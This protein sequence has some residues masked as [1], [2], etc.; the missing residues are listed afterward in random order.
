MKSLF[1][2]AGGTYRMEKDYLIPNLMLPTE[3]KPIGIYGQRHLQYLKENHRCTYTNLL[4]SG[5]LNYYL[6]DIDEQANK[7]FEL[8]MK[9]MAEKQGVTERLK[10]INQFEWVGRM[11]NIK[12]CVEGIV[13]NRIVYN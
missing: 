2:Q 7:M 1:E 12:A 3:N 6:A 8:L 5:G 9:Q 13:M 4:T 11:N 10:A